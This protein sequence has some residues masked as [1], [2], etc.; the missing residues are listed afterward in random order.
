MPCWLALKQNKIQKKGNTEICT[1]EKCCPQKATQIWFT[2]MFH[3]IWLVKRNL[4]KS[5]HK[6]LDVE[7]ERS[8]EKNLNNMK[9]ANGSWASNKYPI[10]L[11]SKSKAQTKLA[12]KRWPAT[13]FARSWGGS[14]PVASNK[15]TFRHTLSPLGFSLSLAAKINQIIQ[16]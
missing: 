8:V 10:K 2:K 12:N 4:L 3:L 7:L 14:E 5:I 6:N 11:C 1:E 15:K 13:T 9:L 16:F